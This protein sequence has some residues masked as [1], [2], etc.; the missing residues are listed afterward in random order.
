MLYLHHPESFVNVLETCV[1]DIPESSVNIHPHKNVF[2]VFDEV[3]L[4]YE[5]YNNLKKT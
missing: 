1:W 5:M 3:N 4:H 2:L